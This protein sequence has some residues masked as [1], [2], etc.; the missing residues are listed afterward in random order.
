MRNRIRAG[1]LSRPMMLGKPVYGQDSAGA[2][3]IASWSE[4]AVYALIEPLSGREWLAVAMMKD[5]V[6][7]KITLRY[8]PSLIPNATW[9]LRDPNTGMVYNITTVMV[10]PRNALVE[11]M[12]RTVPSNTDGR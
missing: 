10:D 7:S 6:D 5:A 9:R 3:T 1:D 2:Q 8:I 12:C 11:T 4:S